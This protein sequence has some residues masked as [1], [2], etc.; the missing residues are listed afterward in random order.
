MSAPAIIW[1][2]DD[3]R[4]ADNPALH[5]AAAS[6]R[7]LIAA[8]VHDEASPGLR[9]IGG[10]ARW[11]LHGG[12]AS[13]DKALQQLGGRLVVL[14]GAAAAAIERLAAAAGA[15]AVYWNRRYG[16]PERQVDG[17]AKAALKARGIVAESFNGALLREPWTV[18]TQSGTPFRVFTAYWRAAQRLDEPAR[19][20]AAPRSLTFHPL[21]SAVTA[22]AVDLADLALEPLKPDWAGGLRAAWQRGEMAARRQLDDFVSSGLEGYRS[23]RD[24]M[25]EAGTSR[26]SPYLRFGHLSARQ[27]WHSAMAAALSRQGP[28]QAPHLDTFLAEIGWREFWHHLLYHE[29]DLAHRNLRPTFDGMP[30]RDDP[31]GLRAWQRGRTGY[32]IVD[33]GM[34]ELWTTGWMHNRARM[35]AASFLVKDLLID[36][37]AGEAWF[38]DTLV[39][40]DPASNPANWQWVAGSGTDAAPYFRIFNPTLQ[41]EKFDPDGAYVRRWVPELAHLPASI[42]HRPW[43][44]ASPL[45]DY[46]PPVVEH[47]AAR[48]RAL[49]AW[50]SI[51]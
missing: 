40:A 34:R 1:F 22:H 46:P 27:V 17:A 19:P 39:D 24:R 44:A 16:A 33:A 11:W 32:P 43:A 23:A 35:I 41:G 48:R 6:G 30:W 50:R 4:L 5:A 2:R 47:D 13:L 51:A 12:L 10:A 21:E 7:P 38:W 28:A 18:L 49:A 3:L 45:A 26:L 42:I 8:Y 37:R 20:L 14:R 15:D 9:P 29:G 31:A 36:W 25:G